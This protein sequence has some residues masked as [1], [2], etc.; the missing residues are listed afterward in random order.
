M[1]S[2]HVLLSL[3]L[4]AGL[5]TQQQLHQV[6][7]DVST[8]VSLGFSTPCFTQYRW[9]QDEMGQLFWHF[10]SISESFSYLSPRMYPMEI[11]RVDMAEKNL[12]IDCVRILFR[13]APA[14]SMTIDCHDHVFYSEKT[15]WDDANFMWK[16]RHASKG[17]RIITLVETLT[18]QFRRIGQILLESEMTMLSKISLTTRFCFSPV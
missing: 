10:A 16:W 3:L 7:L 11:H 17:Y 2:F 8:T 9:H 4:T 5:H 6:S 1:L 12:T 18:I 14:P 13:T 15:I